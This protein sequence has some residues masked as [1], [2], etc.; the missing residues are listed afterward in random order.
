MHEIPSKMVFRRAVQNRHSA[1]DCQSTNSTKMKTALLLALAVSFLA[2]LLTMDGGVRAWDGDDDADE[3]EEEDDDD[4]DFMSS[5]V[6][7]RPWFRSP[8]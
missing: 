2:L 4:F 6:R 7:T 3:V 8:I 1:Q 5:T